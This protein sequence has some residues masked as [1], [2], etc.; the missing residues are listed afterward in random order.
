MEYHGTVDGIQILLLLN[1]ALLSSV[2]EKI[3]E[4][5]E[6]KD[7]ST[8]GFKAKVATWGKGIGL[9]GNNNIQNR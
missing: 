1:Y 2:Y 7:R 4:K 6:E 3:K 9:R 8:T 5:I